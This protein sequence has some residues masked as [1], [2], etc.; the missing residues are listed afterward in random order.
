MPSD[1]NKQNYKHSDFTVTKYS[2]ERQDICHICADDIMEGQIYRNVRH[3]T[4]NTVFNVGTCCA[5]NDKIA[6]DRA[7]YLQNL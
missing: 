2:A 7:A 4:L 6:I 3:N 1:V 5:S